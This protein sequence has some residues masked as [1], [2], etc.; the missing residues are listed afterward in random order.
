M[1]DQRSVD[2]LIDHLRTQVADLRRMQ[3]EGADADE[4]E[5][6]ERLILRLQRHLAHCV[7]DRVE[8]RA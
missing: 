7:V 6:R 3:R 2:R 8:V 4:V 5:A 1:T